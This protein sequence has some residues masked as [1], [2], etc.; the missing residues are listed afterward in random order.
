VPVPV[1]I[2]RYDIQQEIRSQVFAL[3]L[4]DHLGES[5]L[6]LANSKSSPRFTTRVLH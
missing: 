4:P 6:G 1:Q 5:G 3:K 2:T